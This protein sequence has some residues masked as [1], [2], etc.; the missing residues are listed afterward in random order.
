[1]DVERS[2]KA[3]QSL[4]EVNQG[5][6]NRLNDHIAG[7]IYN[8]ESELEKLEKN[9]D[10]LQK[11]GASTSRDAQRINEFDLLFG[12]VKGGSSLRKE[13]TTSLLTGH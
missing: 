6:I 4:A 8:D 13:G 9:L 11:A 7:R 3:Q 12:L 1:M 5:P 10:K 2:F